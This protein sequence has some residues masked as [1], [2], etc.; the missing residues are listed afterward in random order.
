MVHGFVIYLIRK[1]IKNSL[2]SYKYL[3]YF[4]YKK[5]DINCKFY[6]II[7]NYN[8]DSLIIALYKY[9]LIHIFVRFKKFHNK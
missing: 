7:L 9:D 3:L 8:L 2:H 1:Y 4:K 6:N 5:S